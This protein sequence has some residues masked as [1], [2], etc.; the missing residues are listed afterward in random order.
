MS[1]TPRRGWRETIEPG[2][3]RAHRLACP[4]SADRRPGRRC[5]CP[6]QIQAP[7]ARPGATRFVSVPGTVGEARAER[8][9][10]LAA[11]RSESAA[12]HPA[13]G[14]DTLDAFAAHYLRAKSAVL[15]PA[16][17][18]TTEESYRLRV[19]PE[20]GGLRLDEITRERVE[21][22]LAQLVGRASSRRMVT[23]TVEALRV[24][25]AAAVAWGRIPTN[26]ASGLRVPRTDGHQERSVE[27]VIDQAQLGLLLSQGARTLAAETIFR[28]AGEAG[29]RRGEVIGLKWPDVNLPARRLEVR[30]GVW[31][32]REPGGWRIEKSTKGRRARRVAITEAFASRLADLYAQSV[33][34]G[35][36]DAAGHV[37]PGRRG[38]AM[39]ADSPG[40]LLERALRRCGLVDGNDRPLVSFHGLRHSAGSIMLAAGV[41]LIVVSRQL[42]HANPQITATVYAHLL[43]DSELDRAAGV[44]EPRDSARTMRETMRESGAPKQTRM[45]TGISSA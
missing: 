41:P 27:R 7:G 22:W 1:D 19:S 23:K 28:A 34:E 42:G 38:G 17:I 43:S 21:V 31:Q 14:S 29:L 33:V 37:W 11:G 3:Y 18:Y 24:I 45:D 44:F 32:E 5:R 20:L 16:T 4:S 39:A 35:G 8:R 25:L 12:D 13:V 36:A 40:Q 2:L 10:L 15:A 26:P 6:F 9:R 30:R